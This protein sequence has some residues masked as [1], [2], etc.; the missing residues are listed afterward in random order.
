MAFDTVFREDLE[1][2]FFFA[3]ILAMHTKGEAVPELLALCDSLRDVTP[4]VTMRKGNPR[5]TIDL[6]GTGGDQIKTLNVST[7]AAVVVAS[8]GVTV[9]KQAFFGVTG[10]GGSADLL[11]RLGVSVPAI[12]ADPARAVSVLESTG[13]L[14]YHFLFDFPAECKGLGS[15]VKKRVE[16]GLNFVTPMH[17]AAFAYSPFPME[18]RLYGVYSSRYLEPLAEVFTQLGY[19]RGMVVHGSAGLDEISV[20]GT[21]EVCEFSEGKTRRYQIRPED[22]GLRTATP[23]EIAAESFEGN[24]RDFLRVVYGAE[25]GPKKDMVC[26]NAGAALYLVGKAGSLSEGTRGA[27]RL[28]EDGSASRKLEEYVRACGD[29]GVLERLKAQHVPRARWPREEQSLQNR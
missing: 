11:G 8:A 3:L 12:S 9:P 10:F 22:L 25:P 7:A 6:S 15:W 2:Y 1:S 4:K 19:K 26:A 17:V 23:G 24:V 5:N 28:I 16:I 21:T 27:E 18:C 29:P 20:I 13:L 14:T